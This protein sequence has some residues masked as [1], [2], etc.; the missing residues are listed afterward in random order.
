MTKNKFLDD[1]INRLSE[2]SRNDRGITSAVFIN[3]DEARELLESDY[4]KRDDITLFD[5]PEQL[6]DDILKR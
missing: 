4:V 6:H 5:I 2:I 3:S 1:L